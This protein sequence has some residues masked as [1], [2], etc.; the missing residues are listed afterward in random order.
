MNHKE[1]VDILC[2]EIYDAD[3]TIDD[4]E[5]RISDMRDELNFV[6]GRK[7]LSCSLLHVAERVE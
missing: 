5:E 1:I 4:L 2:E 3:C 7:C 6:R